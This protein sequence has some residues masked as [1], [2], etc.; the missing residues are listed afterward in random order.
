[1]LN[2][3]EKK[4]IELRYNGYTYG[5]IEKALGYKIPK[6]TLQNWFMNGGRLYASYL[7]YIQQIDQITTD[8]VVK[9]FRRDSAHAPTMFRSLYQLAVKAKDYTL[10]YRIVCEQL[11]RAGIVTVHKVETKQTY[12]A[13]EKQLTMEQL[14]EQ[15]RQQGIDPLTGIAVKRIAAPQSN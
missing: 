9:E 1:M 5:E 4:A 10:A 12:K 15:L 8:E 2:K 11:D 6:G 13:P 3:Y 14:Y 7:Q